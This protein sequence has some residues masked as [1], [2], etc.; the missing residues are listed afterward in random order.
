MKFAENMYFF[1]HDMLNIVNISKNR[2]KHCSGDTTSR[3]APGTPTHQN[4]QNLK[5]MLH[6]AP[7]EYNLSH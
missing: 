7:S 4:R 3:L 1:Q 6:A 5:I 2:S